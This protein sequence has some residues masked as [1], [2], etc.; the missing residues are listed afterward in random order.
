MIVTLEPVSILCRPLFILLPSPLLFRE[1]T[2]IASYNSSLFLHGITSLE[3]ILRSQKVELCNRQ[4]EGWINR[5]RKYPALFGFRHNY[6]GYA[7]PILNIL[8]PHVGHV[9]WVAGLPF[10]MVIAFVQEFIQLIYI[11]TTDKHLFY[12]GPGFPIV[13][14]IHHAG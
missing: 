7:F 13:F 10:F 9:P 2:H 4:R 11:P 5:R 3:V 14:L 1:D 8:V 12:I 6:Q